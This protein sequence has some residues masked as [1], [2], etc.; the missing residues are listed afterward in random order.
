M[1]V[2]SWLPQAGQTFQFD[3][4]SILFIVIVLI[5]ILSAA[6]KGFLRALLQTVASIASFILA[7]MFCKQVGAMLFNTGLGQFVY[8]PIF[9]WISSKGDVFNTP[10]NQGNL[11]T[12]LPQAYA[13]LGVPSFLSP[14]LTALITQLKIIPETGDIVLSIAFSQTISAYAFIGAAWVLISVGV[15]LVASILLLILRNVIKKL[16][17]SF[18]DHFLGGII[19][20]VTGSLVAIIVAYIL[21]ILLTVGPVG[22]FIKPL[23]AWDDPNTYTITKGLCS[24]ATDIAGLFIK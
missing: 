2:E 12:M 7:S 19:G 18:F 11:E 8:N 20:V 15:S 9:N 14:L 4:V 13:A 6:K 1:V 3:F 17:I 21:V 23:I 16:N 24:M 22:D 10:I 5:S